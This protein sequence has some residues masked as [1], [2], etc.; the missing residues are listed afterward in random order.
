MFGIYISKESILGNAPLPEDKL[1][2]IGKNAIEAIHEIDHAGDNISNRGYI[3]IAFRSNNSRKVNLVD[4]ID[5]VQNL[6][7]ALLEWENSEKING[8]IDT[9]VIDRDLNPDLFRNHYK[10]HSINKLAGSLYEVSKFTRHDYSVKDETKKEGE[11][12]SLMTSIEENNTVKDI[13]KQKTTGTTNSKPK[14]PK[15]GFWDNFRLI[16]VLSV[17][18]AGLVLFYTVVGNPDSFPSIFKLIVNIFAIVALFFVCS[19][20]GALVS[21]YLFH[22]NSE[23]IITNFIRGLIV[24]ALIFL[25]SWL[26][27]DFSGMFDSRGAP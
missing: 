10:T 1:F 16:V 26:S 9:V 15:S 24:L 8:R 13:E 27:F 25:F 18:L 19:L 11:G 4:Y 5:T 23:S 20:L 12:T 7:D 6:K 3:R 2:V 22:D 17:F 21:E 14:K